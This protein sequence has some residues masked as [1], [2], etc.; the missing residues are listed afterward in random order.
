MLRVAIA[1]LFLAAAVRAE[2]SQDACDE[3][4]G[5]SLLQA[6]ASQPT[7]AQQPA[8]PPAGTGGEVCPPPGFDSVEP[9]NISD[10]ISALW[11]IQM[12]SEVGYLPKERFFCV[13]ANY[14][15]TAP[16]TGPLFQSEAEL[17]VDNYAREGSTS[18][19]DSF[20][21]GI[22]L[23]ASIV[24]LSQPSKLLVGPP[25][26]PVRARGPYWVVAVSEQ[27]YEWA[28]VSGGPPTIQG[29]GGCR[30]QEP[31]RENNRNGNEEGL[32]LLTREPVAPNSTVDMLVEKASALGFDTSVLL[33]VEQ[34]GCCGETYGVP[35]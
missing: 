21:R 15:E 23:R 34:E 22:P 8:G 19:S 31:D 4:E 26:A 32:F 12:Q 35:C 28:I 5:S 18:G 14:T 1:S 11:Y 27:P 10:Y 17:I 25:F 24:D 2:S 13:R 9:F 7:Q 29:A 6:A 30:N 33:P 16:G 3:Q 20:S